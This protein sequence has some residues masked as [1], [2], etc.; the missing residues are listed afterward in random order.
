MQLIKVAAA[1]VNTTP[2]AWD[3]NQAYLLAAIADAPARGVS[4]LCLPAP[5]VPGHGGGGRVQPRGGGA[6]PRR[7]RGVDPLPA[8]AGDHGLR[9]R[10]RLPFGRHLAHSARGLEVDP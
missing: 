2:L 8:G 1:V 4:I 10:G 3:S 6:R 9:L 5:A 7:G